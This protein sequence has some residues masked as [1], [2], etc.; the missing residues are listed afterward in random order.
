MRILLT[1]ATGL[2]GAAILGRLASDGHEVVA[3]TRVCGSA[4]DRLPAHGFVRLDIASATTADR[5]LPHLAGI[6]AV[7]NCAGVL[8]DSPRDSTAGVHALGVPALF[9]ACARAGIRRVVHLSAIGLDRHAP[10]DFSRSKRAGDA[11]L[12]ALDLDWIILRPSVV[13]GRTAYGGSALFRGLAALPLLPVVPGT[14]A[15]QVVQLDDLVETVRFFLSPQAPACLVLEIAGPERLGF[16]AIVAAYRRWLGWPPARTFALPRIL[17]NAMFRLGD[18]ISRLGWRPP[19]R[20]TAQREIARG[21][22]GDPAEWTRI[23]GIRPAALAAALAREPASVQE[24]W[25]ARL[26]LLKPL[27]LGAS[28]AFWV[29]TGL[30]SLGPGWS[31]GMN[32]MRDAGAVAAP[33]VGAGALADIVIGIGIAFRRTARTA[34]LAATAVASLCGL[35]GTILLPGLWADPLAPM[36]KIVPILALTLATLAILDDR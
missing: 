17:A 19:V 32:L 28:V 36:L 18:L 23:T 3:V 8:Q 12:M 2:I 1:G 11:A 30:V 24:R 4:A 9:A 26:Y 14:E 33:L 34:L 10:T 29:G 5:W 13:V 31:V 7:V 15:L 21:A 35:A 16:G 25:F 22:I 27:M 6:D 20:T